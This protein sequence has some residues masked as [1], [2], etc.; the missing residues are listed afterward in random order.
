MPAVE[1]RTEGHVAVLT[2]NRPEARNALN[3]AVCD[4]LGAGQAEVE[5]NPDIRVGV[6][7][8]AGGY[9][10][11]GMDLKAFVAGEKV[12]TR[13]IPFGGKDNAVIT[14]PLVAAV[15]GYALAGGFELAM[16]CDLIV[17]SRTAK[18][19]LPEVKRG[20]V[21]AGG[22]LMRLPREAPIRIAMEMVLTGDMFDAETLHSHGVI[23]RLAPEGG[24]L[25]AAIELA[26]RIAQNAPIALAVSKKVMRD[27]LDW[28]N[29]EAFDRQREFTAPV[30]QTNDAREGAV[31]FAEKRPPRWTGT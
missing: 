10:C 2:I 1:F 7:T 8:G 11:S 28:P 26:G 16:I 19:G 27:S 9:F 14:K 30:F 31:A 22:G 13:G 23:N 20:L 15:E 3:A 24:A 17:S 6:L 29:S 18:F 12:D 21:A 5:R 25:E 4:G